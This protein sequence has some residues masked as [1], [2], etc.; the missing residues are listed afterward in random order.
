VIRD[1][2]DDLWQSRAAGL[3]GLKADSPTD[4]TPAETADGLDA[5]PAHSNISP[6]GVIGVVTSNDHQ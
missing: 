5:E 6:N 4:F 1:L 2:T 3:A